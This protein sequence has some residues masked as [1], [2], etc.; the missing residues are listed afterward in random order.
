M[1]RDVTY[2][3]YICVIGTHGMRQAEVIAQLIR[4]TK[5][6]NGSANILVHFLCSLL[7]FADRYVC[8]FHDF[9]A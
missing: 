4:I 2:L 5:T 7:S 3:D 6:L 8:L 1:F 9:T